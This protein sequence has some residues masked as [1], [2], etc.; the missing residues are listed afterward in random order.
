[1]VRPLICG[2]ISKLVSPKV[3]LVNIECLYQKT[4]LSLGAT[5]EYCCCCCH[6]Y[7]SYLLFLLLLL[8]K[9]LNMLGVSNSHYVSVSVG[10]I[11][12]MLELHDSLTQDLIFK[13]LLQPL[14]N[15]IRK[16]KS[17]C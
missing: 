5:F 14:L 8:L 1:M 9:V 3:C 17:F 6:C 15:F 4:M 2:S 16:G 12:E 13:P 7:C 10:C 11:Q